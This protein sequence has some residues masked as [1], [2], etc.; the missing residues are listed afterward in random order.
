MDELARIAEILRPLWPGVVMVTNGQRMH[1]NNGRIR[2]TVEV[3]VTSDA[4]LTVNNKEFSR[5]RWGDIKGAE[6][7]LAQQRDHARMT[8]DALNAALGLE[9][10]DG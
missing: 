9:V 1:G 3:G 5:A 2:L 8:A 6:R 7:A 10:S 4:V